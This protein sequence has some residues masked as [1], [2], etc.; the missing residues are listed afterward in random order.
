MGPFFIAF[1]GLP[2]HPGP[3]PR[4]RGRGGRGERE[5]EGF[6]FLGVAALVYDLSFGT[7]ETFS[8]FPITNVGKDGVDSRLRTAGMTDGFPIKNVGND[9]GAETAGRTGGLECWEGWVKRW[10]GRGGWDFTG[11]ACYFR[12]RHLLFLVISFN[13]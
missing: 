9:R 7:A 4:G 5:G 13:A 2:P 11:I 1:L 6:R 12:Y 3:L 8:G 10:E